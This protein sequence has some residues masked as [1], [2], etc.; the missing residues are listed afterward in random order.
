MDE[1]LPRFENAVK[2][3]YEAV[4]L[5]RTCR[6]AASISIYT[7]SSAQAPISAV[8]KRPCSNRS[9]ASRVGRASSRRSRP[10]SACTVSRRR[11]TTR[12]V[13]RA[14]HRSFRKGAAWFA[15]LGPEGSGGTAQ[16]SVSGHVEKPGNFELP[17]GI[18]FK[19]L[20]E[21][22]CGGVWKGPQAEGRHPRRLVVQGHAGG[23]HHGLHDGLQLAAG[24]GFV[25]RHRRGHGHGRDKPAW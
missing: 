15:G 4:C 6:A 24:G 16:F 11:S 25:V 12:R 22:I 23:D 20:L 10:T 3:A 17:M 5:A 7:V 18:P 1:P 21:E 14:C 19:V 9:K 2:E 8:R 13:L